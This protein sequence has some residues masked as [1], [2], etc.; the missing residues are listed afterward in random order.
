M[1]NPDKNRTL[2]IVLFQLGGPESLDDVQPFLESMFRDPDLFKLPIPGWLRSGLARRL[3]KWRA[4]KV[5]ELYASIGGKSTIGEVTR[6]QAEL[7]E[8]EL[9]PAGPCRVFVAMRHGRPSSTDTIR[10]IRHANCGRLVLLPLYPHYS[11]ATTGSSLREWERCC[12]AAGLD[13]PTAE[14][15]SYA[16]S[17]AYI[18]ALVERIVE[19]RTR[20][21]ANC[22]PHLVFSAHGLP[23]KLVERGDPY[24][25]QIA[26]SVRLVLDQCDPNTPHTLCYQ[27][28]VGPQR[29]LEPS[30]SETLRRLGRSNVQEVLVVPISF[31]SDHLETLS[32][33]DIEARAEAI[34]WGVRRFETTLGLNDSP[35]FIRALAD[36]VR[37]CAQHLP[38]L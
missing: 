34:R 33:I 35:T 7:L 36:L 10:S 37:N 13:L 14:I 22:K 29:W 17:P 24:P 8:V 16:S 20:F 30:L 9:S 4:A 32:E 2:G 3:S 27:S 26:E 5:R 23:R 25:E 12:R 31:V 15:Q 1:G 19:A 38:A 18:E 21:P 11:T 28:K 6:R